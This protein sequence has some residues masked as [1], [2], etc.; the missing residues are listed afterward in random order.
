MWNPAKWRHLHTDL[1]E[2]AVPSRRAIWNSA[3]VCLPWKELFSW[4]NA[5]FT[6]TLKFPPARTKQKGTKEPQNHRISSLLSNICDHRAT[7]AITFSQISCL[8]DIGPLYSTINCELTSMW[9][10]DPNSGI[11]YLLLVH[12][13]TLVCVL[14]TWAS[15]LMICWWFHLDWERISYFRKTSGTEEGKRTR[16]KKE[17]QEGFV[18]DFVVA[19]L[20]KWTVMIQCSCWS[21]R[22]S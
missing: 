11:C 18:A 3:Q 15:S 21:S 13:H 5:I 20:N 1:E 4:N 22:L 16:R 2:C 19:E 6:L 12:F 14:W 8:L 10:S 9:E 17:S 7:R